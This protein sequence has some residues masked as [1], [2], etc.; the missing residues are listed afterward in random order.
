M[1]GLAPSSHEKRL[2]YASSYQRTYNVFELQLGL[3][4]WTRQISGL[5]PIGGDL[6][7]FVCVMFA[8]EQAGA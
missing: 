1:H 3:N 8:H 2:Q 5:S 4:F 6:K 7:C